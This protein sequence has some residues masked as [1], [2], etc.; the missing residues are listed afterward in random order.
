MAD[1][2]RLLELMNPGSSAATKRL[3]VDLDRLRAELFESCAA[4]ER[5]PT[6]NNRDRVRVDAADVAKWQA[7]LSESIAADARARERWRDLAFHQSPPER[8]NRTVVYALVTAAILLV[9]G[10]LL[11]GYLAAA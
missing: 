11:I 3:R 5:D 10:A 4:A 6:E 2:A 8:N 7:M 9:V 1:Y